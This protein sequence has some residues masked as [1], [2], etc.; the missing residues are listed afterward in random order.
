MTNRRATAACLAWVALL[1]L[2]SLGVAVPFVDGATAGVTSDGAR[3]AI[4]SGYAALPLLAGWLAGFVALCS[5]VQR[6]SPGVQQV[7]ASRQAPMYSA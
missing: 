2:P 6:T 5:R 7:T 1:A 4:D 3:A